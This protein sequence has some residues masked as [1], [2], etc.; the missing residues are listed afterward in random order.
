MARPPYLMAMS[1]EKSDRLEIQLFNVATKYGE[2]P[3][4]L[5]VPVLHVRARDR[6]RSSRGTPKSINLRKVRIPTTT[7]S[8][9]TLPGKMQIIIGLHFRLI[10]PSDGPLV[11]GVGALGRCSLSARILFKVM[12]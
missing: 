3:P 5:V 9:P 4:I 1:N 11:A 6:P 10:A 2:S 12:V 7:H 8:T